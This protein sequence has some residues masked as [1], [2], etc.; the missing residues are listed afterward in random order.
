M[1]AAR[2]DQRRH[3]VGFLVSLVLL[4]IPSI[5]WG[6]VAAPVPAAASD[7]TSRPFSTIFSGLVQDFGN[8]GQKQPLIVF[9]VG[10][11]L[12]GLAIHTDGEIRDRMINK[13]IR[14]E[15]AFDPGD[16]IGS[17]YVQFGAAMATYAWGRVSH[18]SRLTEV[19]ADLAETQIVSGA[20]TQGAKL[21][22]S[23]P[24][25]DGGGRSFPSGH[26]SATFATAT[27][28]QRHFGWKVGAIAYAG[29]I[30]VGASRLT[31][32]QHYLTDVVA[33]AAI[34]IGSALAQGF[35]R[36]PAHVTVTPV[37]MKGGAA[38]FVSA[39]PQ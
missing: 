37:A 21:I 4:V 16:I 14:V 22:V 24:R 38:V 36:S 20:L 27:V 23:R 8:L 26:T 32:N 12:T 18:K 11:V 7:K 29:A 17:G 31:E 19:G 9:G 6:Q 25:P 30:Y 39:L 35:G 34:G 5:S 28:L 10:G 13:P 15:D 1:P 33:G 3:G 2:S